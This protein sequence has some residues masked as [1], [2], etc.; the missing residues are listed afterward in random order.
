MLKAQ[1]A[2]HAA[3]IVLALCLPAAGALA[4]S[5]SACI[6]ELQKEYG[7]TPALR[8]ECDGK[9]DCTFQAPEGNASALALIET[10][11]KR[12]ETCLGEAGLSVT[13]EEKAEGVTR[14]YGAPGASEMCALLTAPGAGAPQGVRLACQPAK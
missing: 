12:A 14:Y 8:S 1:R 13:K 2:S 4:K 9:T 3:A 11:V 10:I 6:A 7:A 5:P